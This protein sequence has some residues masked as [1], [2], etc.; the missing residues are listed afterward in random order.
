MI[1]VD[2]CNRRHHAIY[3]YLPI[4]FYAPSRKGGGAGLTF[5]LSG[6]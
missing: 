2:A 4:I 5:R 1:D 3:H 6:A